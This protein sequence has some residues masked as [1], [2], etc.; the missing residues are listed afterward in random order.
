MMVEG[1]SKEVSETLMLEALKVAH[2]AIKIQ[3][4]AQIDLAKQVEKAAVK[5]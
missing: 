5:T 4:Q 1:E 2:E 3:C